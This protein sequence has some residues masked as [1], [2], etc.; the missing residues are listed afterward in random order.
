MANSLQARVNGAASAWIDHPIIAA[1]M[2]VGGGFILS[3]VIVLMRQSTRSAAWKLFSHIKTGQLKRWYYFAGV[4]GGIFILGQAL[5][6]PTFGVTI[7]II[8]IV[9]GQTVASL[10]VDRVGMGPA[11]AQKITTLRI[12]A[13]ILAVAGVAISSLGRGE[14]K[15]IAI[16]AVLYGLAAGAATAAQYALNGS[17]AQ[18]AGSAMVTSALN[19]GMGFSFLSL[20]LVINTVILG[21]PLVSP[22]SLLE[23]PG[24]WLGGPLGMLFIASAALF[25]RSLGVLVFTLVS[26]AGQLAGAIALDVFFPTP[27]AVLTGLVVVGLVVTAFGVYL[28]TFGRYRNQE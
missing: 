16:A 8:A 18:V 19:F 12:V 23:Q 7:Y 25:V 9:A 11:G 5:V 21:N 27:G 1:M 3:A 28:S 20:L 13:S 17:I 22:P 4:G 26:V 10:L 15:T 2:S 14:V 24:L 6:V